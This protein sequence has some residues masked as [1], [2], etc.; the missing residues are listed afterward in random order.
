MARQAQTIERERHGIWAHIA[1]TACTLAVLGSAAFWLVRPDGHTPRFAG[2][3]MVGARG[4]GAAPRG[5][6]AEQYAEDRR[7]RSGPEAAEAESTTRGGLAERYAEQQA[8]MT[9]ATADPTGLAVQAP[10]PVRT[11]YLVGSE[12]A[13]AAARDAWAAGESQRAALGLLPEAVQVLV[14]ETDEDAAQVRAGVG[15]AQTRVIDLRG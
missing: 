3:A 6:L 14:V 2:V 5:G 11:I 8:A 7:A 12:A 1:A 4:E 10:S 15:G 9:G 13:A